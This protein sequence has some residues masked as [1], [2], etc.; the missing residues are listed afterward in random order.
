MIK[1][2]REQQFELRE[3]IILDHAYK[4][5]LEQGYEKM[6]MD[7]LAAQVGIAKMTVYQHFPSKEALAIAVIVRGMKQVEETLTPVFDSPRPALERLHEV[8]S[9]GLEQRSKIWRIHLELPPSAVIHN[10]AYQT[11]NARFLEH[12]ERLIEQ[13]KAEGAIAP[14]LSTLVLIRMF[15]IMYQTDYEDL[16]DSGKVTIETLIDTLMTVAINGIK[17]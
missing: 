12:W 6:S 5:M 3:T 7:Q 1:S 8:L 15:Q 16:L 17:R 9:K 2:V 4:L 10:V 13:A 14:T 11:Q